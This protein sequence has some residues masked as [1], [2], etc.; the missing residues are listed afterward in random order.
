MKRM[1]SLATRAFVFSFV[2]VC[3]VLAVSFFALSTAMERHV[4]AGLRD[5]IEKSELLLQKTHKESAARLAQ[6]AAGMADSAGLKSTIQLAHENGATPEGEAEARRTIEAQLTE[7]HKLV[8]YDLLAVTD[9][10]GQTLGAMEFGGGAAH[11]P[12]QMPV[13]SDSPSLTGSMTRNYGG[14]GLG[15]TIVR[16]LMELMG[17][18]VSVDSRLG[19]GSTF[20]AVLPL[21][22]AGGEPQAGDGTRDRAEAT[23]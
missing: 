15:L 21:H 11:P 20:R 2:P 1:N 14:T 19:E 8:G 10:N 3:L 22:L 18:S 4:R 13:F 5:S 9:W 23:C 17:G 16:Q 12:A 6:F 7:I